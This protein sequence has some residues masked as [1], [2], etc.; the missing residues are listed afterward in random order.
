MSLPHTLQK[1]PGGRW[2]GLKAPQVGKE[3]LVPS[4][5]LSLRDPRLEGK[6][7]ASCETSRPR[8]PLRS[9]KRGR[10]LEQTHGRVDSRSHRGYQ[11][12]REAGSEARGDVAGR[13][14]M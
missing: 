14:L 10:S 11:G 4:L 8:D 9:G 12:E 3:S 6:K 2:S 5:E 1:S 7:L 13:E